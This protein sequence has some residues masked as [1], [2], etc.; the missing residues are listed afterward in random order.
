MDP[1]AKIRLGRIRFRLAIISLSSGRIR[2]NKNPGN[3]ILKNDVPK[4]KNEER[5]QW[6]RTGGAKIPGK[7]QGKIAKQR[8]RNMKLPELTLG[9]SV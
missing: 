5:I 3:G 6:R 9:V 4:K 1:T 8:S 7:P 2:R